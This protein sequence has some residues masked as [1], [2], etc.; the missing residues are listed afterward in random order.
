M[1]SNLIA[2][3]ILL[4]ASGA[5]AQNYE[6]ALPDYSYRFPQ[7]N[8]NHPNYQTEWWY[9]TGNLRSSDGHRFGFELT[10][11]RQAVAR[12]TDSSTWHVHDLYLAHLALSD[13]TGHRFYS[14]ERIN[15][16]GPGIAGIDEKT[17]LIWNGNWQA[18]LR[19]DSQS[20]RA[21]YDNFAFE[22]TLMPEKP[23]VINGKNGI[24]QK[25]EG[26]GHASHYISLTRL[27]THGSIQLNGKAYA[28][29]G[30]AWMDHEF[31]TGSMGADE[32]G[33]DW[34]S[35]QLDDNTELMLYRLRHKDGT[36][37]PY[38]S[39]TYIDAQGKTLHLSEKDFTMTSGGITW[40]SP[41]SA[42]T[43]P[44]AWRVSV[45][46]FGLQ[47]EV[48]TPLKDQELISRVGPSY[49]E[50]AIDIAGRRNGGAVQGVGYLEMTGYSHLNP[51]PSVQ[52]ASKSE[53]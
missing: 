20:L 38:S 29:Q 31:F 28:V 46:Q 24:S 40:T 33:W 37:D 12:D 11:F 6:I 53:R 26:V 18:E 21:V 13:V 9:Y 49:W 39:G 35:L 14:T 41:A 50:G 2:V 16:S 22:L 43:Y 1:K 36:V 23:A 47:L 10:F 52:Q 19:N 44:I 48:R 51:W 30:T 15:R 34:L 5:C 32:R 25:A 4:L 3:L 27:L 7:D 42:G 17:G 8:F 45:P